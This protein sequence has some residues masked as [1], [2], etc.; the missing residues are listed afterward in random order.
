MKILLTGSSGFIGQALKNFLEK[1]GIT[2]IPFDPKTDPKNNILNLESLKI[3][4]KQVDGVIHLAALSQPKAN[5]ENPRNC[6]NINIIGTNNILEAVRQAKNQRPWVIFISSREVFGESAILPITEKTPKNP[7][8]IYGITKAIGEELCRIFSESYG[9]KTRILRLTSVYSG[10]NDQLDRVIPRFIIQASRNEPLIIYGTGQELFD[11]TYI[12]DIVQGIKS[13]VIELQK[14]RKMH[15]DF[16][17]SFGQ[18]V[19][20]KDLAQ[21]IIGE[22]GSKSFINYEKKYQFSTIKCYADNRKA[23]EFLN[24]N[25]KIN[26]REGIKL[27]IKE[28]KEAKII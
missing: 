27:V 23:K 9:L 25:P 2:V 20:L 19:S 10:K 26:I 6:V 24:F 1:E 4:V 28:F 15:D 12:S 5:Y 3:N 8:S 18:P 11:F 17:L 21:I 7:A 22:T 14:S 13:C 16:I